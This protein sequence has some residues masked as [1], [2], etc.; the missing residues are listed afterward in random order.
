M[1]A[2][3]YQ[4]LSCNKKKPLQVLISQ[5]YQNLSCGDDDTANPIY[6][7][8]LHFTSKSLLYWI[9]GRYHEVLYI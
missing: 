6:L 8:L 4:R 2:R 3:V 7:T 9:F 5:G 1:T